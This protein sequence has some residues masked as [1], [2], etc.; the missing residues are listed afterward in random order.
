LAVLTG[1]L[2]TASF[3]PAGM[4]WLV[5]FALVPLLMSLENQPFAAA[6]RLGFITGLSHY[7][8]LI[9]WIVFVLGHY[10]NLSIPLSIGPL[11]L[12]C[13]YLA[14]YPAFFAGLAVFLPA[15]PFRSLLIGALWVALE[16]VRTNLLTGFPWCLLGY[17]LFQSVHLI[18]LADI[19]GVYGL[20]F[21][22]VLINWLGYSCLGHLRTRSAEFLK[23]QILTAALALAAALGYGHFR[24]GGDERPT[25][26]K[27]PLKVALI[28]ANIDQSVKWN[29]AYQAKTMKVYAKLSRSARSFEPD[30]IVWPETA[31]PFFFQN[32]QAF[33]ENLRALAKELETPLIFGSPG[34]G[35]ENS[36]TKYYNRAYFIT[37]DKQPEQYYDKVHLVPF[38]E[39]VPLKKLLF[40]VDRLVTAAGDFDPGKSLAPLKQDSVAAGILICFEAIFPELARGHTK[41]GANI[42]VNLTNDAWFGR[43]SAPYQHLSMAVFRAVENRRPLLR[44]ANTGFS[45]VVS[46]CGRIRK[47]SPLFS[48]AVLRA[49]VDISPA[50]RT[51]YTRFG[52]VFAL[53]AAGVA[54]LWVLAGIYRRFKS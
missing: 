52:D 16:Y 10:G 30:L 24:L 12:L 14:V 46:P 2:L 3:P 29:P 7:L 23:W 21:L 5:W 35:K 53:A 31:L 45:A 32:N 36:A 8:T 47:K 6:F 42:L 11:L 37:P 26:A 49:I 39:Y 22:I 13:A 40:F 25:T 19:T 28:Q 20:S 38:G 33:A 27:H 43:T 17:S 4:S 15:P 48:Q 1:I 41:T 34:Y 9:Y 18:Q 44:A 50:R 54:L 51:F